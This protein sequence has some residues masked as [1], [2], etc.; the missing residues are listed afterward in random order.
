MTAAIAVEALGADN[1]KAVTMPSQYTSGETL[2]DAGELAQKPGH[3]AE[4]HTHQTHIAKLFARVGK[5]R[6]AGAIWACPART[7]RPASGAISSW[8]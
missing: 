4:H 6:W 7:C 3:R 5:A 1:V 2:G 8:P